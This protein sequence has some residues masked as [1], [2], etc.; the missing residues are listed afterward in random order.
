MSG[1]IINLVRQTTHIGVVLFKT[2]ANLSKDR[3]AKPLGSRFLRDAAGDATKDPKIAELPCSFD[4]RIYNQV[5]K[6]RMRGL[7]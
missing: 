5:H 2:K 4:Y 1:Q 3:D 7:A 6:E